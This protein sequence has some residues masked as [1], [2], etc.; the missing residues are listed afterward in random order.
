MVV[1]VV[2]RRRRSRRSCG[3]RTRSRS[4]SPGSSEPWWATFS[5]STGLRR[6]PRRDVA[7]GV[8]RE[9]HVGR[10]VARERDDGV[11]VR[12]L[13]RKA[14][15]VR[16]EDPELQLADPERPRPHG[17]RRPGLRGRRAAAS[18]ASRSGEGASIPGSPTAPTLS[19]SRTRAAPPMWSRCGCVRTIAVS[20]RSPSRRSWPATSASGG[21]SSTSTA[22]PG[23]ST[24]AESPWPTS[25]NVTR[26]PVGGVHEG[27][28][29]SA[30]ATVDDGQG[31]R[32]ERPRRRSRRR[33]RGRWRTSDECADERR[34][35]HD[36][37]RRRDLC[38]RPARRRPSRRTRATRHTSRRATRARSPHPEAR[39]RS[40][41]R[42]G[43][44]R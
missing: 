30:H 40:P 36:H 25:R 37:G 34:G 2:L 6:Q 21:P 11:L 13:A 20:D 19:R 33:Y 14:R 38:R 9:Q 43:T 12:V 31:E 17:R 42:R 15:V 7:L 1:V 44:A 29:R 8:R 41:P 16:P 28:G 27:V 24:S 39:A 32:H 22:P 4:G 23:A 26:R 10:A 3:R 18:A 5:T 35:D